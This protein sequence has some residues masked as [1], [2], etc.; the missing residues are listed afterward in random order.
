VQA[1]LHTDEYGQ[2]FILPGHSYGLGVAVEKLKIPNDITCLFIG[3]STYCRSGV[4]CN[5][6]PGESGWEGYLTIEVSNSSPADV[7]VYANEGICQ[8]LF[9]ES[10]ECAV[11]YGDRSGKYQNQ[12]QEVTLAKA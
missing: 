2:F 8:V 5:F 10:E 3:K 6:S 1:E 7:R 4:I 9:F 12:A 11:S